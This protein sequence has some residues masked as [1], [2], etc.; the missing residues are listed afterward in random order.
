MLSFGIIRDK[1]IMKLIRSKRERGG[2]TSKW[3]PRR[4]E[5]GPSHCGAPVYISSRP[6]G[7]VRKRG[8]ER[9]RWW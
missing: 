9:N 4:E 5:W 7:I 8:K 3:D 2:V 6:G 1:I